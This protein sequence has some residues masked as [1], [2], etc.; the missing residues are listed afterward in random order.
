M[1]SSQISSKQIT[2]NETQSGASTAPVTDNFFWRCLR[3]LQLPKKQGVPDS[4]K[5]NVP[6]ISPSL[7]NHGVSKGIAACTL[8]TGETNAV[9]LKNGRQLKEL[10][11]AIEENRVQWRFPEETAIPHLYCLLLRGKIE[12][13]NNLAVL[14]MQLQLEHCMRFFPR[15]LPEDAPCQ[16]LPCFVS[17]GSASSRGF[18]IPIGGGGV[19]DLNVGDA[20]RMTKNR[21]IR[22]EQYILDLQRILNGFNNRR[23]SGVAHKENSESVKEAKRLQARIAAEQH[24]Q[25]GLRNAL[26]FL[27]QRPS[28]RGLSTDDVNALCTSVCNVTRMRPVWERLRTGSLE[29]LADR[30]GLE[31]WTSRVVDYAGTAGAPTLGGDATP[32][33][34]LL[35]DQLFLL[36]GRVP[37]AFNV[38]T[39]H[40][41]VSRTSFPWHI[42]ADPNLSAHTEMRLR[43]KE[44]LGCFLSKYP[45]R[46][47]PN[48]LVQV[49]HD[50]LKATTLH[51]K[52]DLFPLKT[53]AE[54]L[55]G[56]G[57]CELSERYVLSARK[58]LELVLLSKDGTPTYYAHAYK[59]DAPD[60]L[61]QIH[62][63][64]EVPAPPDVMASI[65]SLE[66][67]VLEQR[68][69]LNQL[70]S[71]RYTLIHSDQE[72]QT[73]IQQ[74]RTLI[75]EHATRLYQL[76][77]PLAQMARNL[78]GR[79]FSGVDDEE[80]GVIDSCP[81][82]SQERNEHH[83][84]AIYVL[85]AP[86]MMAAIQLD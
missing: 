10:I 12:E 2:E 50:L 4:V 76:K 68:R 22:V 30:V 66:R 33:E 38:G 55:F 59:L 86:L 49:V 17:S 1:S 46:V 28:D 77:Q 44:L 65:E 18:G 15:R 25:S 40:Q 81:S 60:I 79:M 43:I 31:V 26:E 42:P 80:V 74:K 53:I 51:D 37:R 73:L 29:W 57:Q 27:R 19:S 35:S 72:L 6:W 3:L 84:N 32:L 9:Y 41:R 70:Y 83:L 39:T 62:A 34:Q 71:R 8:S 58:A 61:E 11:L 82:D 64:T 20:L 23:A 56:A 5:R 21:S 85:T 54:D 16:P 45:G 47:M 36:V 52:M 69:E 14:I 75:N 48:R 7:Y 67:T 24:C 63:S 13:A 78:I